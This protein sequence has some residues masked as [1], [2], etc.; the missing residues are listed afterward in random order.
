M[1]F[2]SL[3]KTSIVSLPSTVQALISISDPDETIESIE[4]SNSS[5]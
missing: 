4:S 3:I 2:N 5:N 1:I